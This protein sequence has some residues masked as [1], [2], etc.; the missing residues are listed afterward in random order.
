MGKPREYHKSLPAAEVERVVIGACLMNDAFTAEFSQRLKPEMFTVPEHAKMFDAI[1]H[2]FR[3]GMGIDGP[4]VDKAIL[5]QDAERYHLRA[6][7]GESGTPDLGEYLQECIDSYQNADQARGYAKRIMIRHGAEC[8]QAPIAEALAS[9]QNGIAVN[10]IDS[11]MWAE[12]ASRKLYRA[13]ELLKGG[14]SGDGAPMGDRPAPQMV[15]TRLPDTPE[16]WLALDDMLPRPIADFI[17]DTCLSV[18]VPMEFGFATWLGMVSGVLSMSHWVEVTNTFRVPPN[19]WFICGLPSGAG[20]GPVINA[21]TQPLTNFLSHR[22]ES[23]RKATNLKLSAALNLVEMR[24]EA[25]K[26][27]RR[28]L[29]KMVSD[30]AVVDAEAH[31]K[32]MEANAYELAQAE[33]IK[34]TIGNKMK[35]PRLNTISPT[36]DKIP[37]IAAVNPGGVVISMN[38]EAA[39]LE[40]ALSFSNAGRGGLMSLTALLNAYTGGPYTGDRVDSEREVILNSMS[41]AMVL[42]TQPATFDALFCANEQ[43]LNSGL[44]WRFLVCFPKWNGKS[45]VKKWVPP[46]VRQQYFM[47]MEDMFGQLSDYD[48]VEFDS[49][50][51]RGEEA[52]EGEPPRR[53]IYVPFSPEG[54]AYHEAQLAKF[55]P[56]G[57]PYQPLAR[58]ESIINKSELA[59]VKLALVFHFAWKSSVKDAEASM[60]SAESVRRAWATYHFFFDHA[61]RTYVEANV[62]CSA[63]AHRAEQLLNAMRDHPSGKHK[64]WNQNE[65]R[66]L[67]Q[68]DKKAVLLRSIDG[69][70]L[71]RLIEHLERMFLI[72]SDYVQQLIEHKAKAR[73]G[74]L[75]AQTWRLTVE[76]RNYDTKNIGT[77]M[78]AVE[79]PNGK[80]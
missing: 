58:W 6:P 63:L 13:L 80:V 62:N 32:D 66:A 59:V 12:D 19:L 56:Q 5:L 67:C 43:F 47:R 42:G 69:P 79:D 38:E 52:T 17:R 55:I 61:M 46:D 48:F 33:E 14:E 18:E 7:R 31:V 41:I 16:H 28:R 75:K 64:E 54:M 73:G 15:A 10:A 76:G 53:P 23:R 50:I 57:K 24:V 20:K 72:E 34:A 68:R 27:K 77:R 35:M 36:L 21:I 60:I 1:A 51:Y 71:N 65:L 40:N 8:A 39:I 49:R 9:L 2:L 37:H 70:T 45:G 26:Q 4:K 74:R 11:R 25:A 22:I 30:D 3:G 44:L 29:V 78:A